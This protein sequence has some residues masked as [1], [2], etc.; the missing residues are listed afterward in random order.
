VLTW[1]RFAAEEPEMA[2]FGQALLFRHGVGLAFLATTRRD[3][4]PRLHPG[5]PVL[6]GDGLFM[7]VIPSPKRGDLLRDGRFALHS[8]PIDDNEDAFCITGVAQP[9][10]ETALR[11][12]TAAIWFAERSLEHA[13]PGFEDEQLFELLVSGCLTTKTTRHRDYQPDHR[14][15]SAR[16]LP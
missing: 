9:R 5:C 15:W 16:D 2:A 12:S 1:R 13:P 10:D 7:F 6:N 8:F 3:G 11:N 4:G 14:V